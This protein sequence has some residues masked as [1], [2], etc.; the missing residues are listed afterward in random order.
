MKKKKLLAVI[1]IIALTLVFAI[2]LAACTKSGTTTGGDDGTTTG[3]DDGTEDITDP[4]ATPSDVL[5]AA[6]NATLSNLRGF[7]YKQERAYEENGETIGV[8]AETQK[9]LFDAD[10][11]ITHL[12]NRQSEDSDND[13]WFYQTVIVNGML[14]EEYGFEDY[15]QGTKHT[16]TDD[17][18]EDGDY[19]VEALRNISASLNSTNVTKSNGKYTVTLSEEFREELDMPIS[20]LDFTV[21][22]GKVTEITG[23]GEFS[24]DVGEEEEYNISGT[25]TLSVKIYTTANAFSITA[26]TAPEGMTYTEVFVVTF[27][28]P[29][30]SVR[31]GKENTFVITAYD[32]TFPEW[33]S[34]TVQS[35]L[36]VSYVFDDET[37]YS[38]ALFTNAVDID[39]PVTA[40]MT[41]YIKA[42]PRTT[43][44]TALTVLNAIDKSIVKTTY[45]YTL[46]EYSDANQTEVIST[47]IF[48]FGEKYRGQ[49][50][51]LKS[52]FDGERYGEPYKEWYDNSGTSWYGT[53]Y[54]IE[55]GE[56]YF[57]P[58]ASQSYYQSISSIFSSVIISEYFDQFVVTLRTGT[59]D[60]Y[61][62]TLEGTKVAEIVINADGLVKTYKY[63]VYQTLVYAFDYTGSTVI[64]AKPTAEWTTFFKLTVVFNN[65]DEG[66][67][68]WDYVLSLTEEEFYNR[69]SL[70]DYDYTFAYTDRACTIPVVFPLVLTE[71]TTI[72]AKGVNETDP[73]KK[74]IAGLKKNGNQLSWDRVMREANGEEIIDLSYGGQSGTGYAEFAIWGRPWLQISLSGYAWDNIYEDY[75]F[76]YSNYEDEDMTFSVIDTTVIIIW[77]EGEGSSQ[78]SV[79]VRGEIMEIDGTMGILFGVKVNVIGYGEATQYLFL[80]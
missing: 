73:T 51:L 29:A 18:L 35:A 38:T 24:E 30:A 50:T 52:Y 39:A 75:V 8:R 44:A 14:Y 16:V 62:I 61:D 67:S 23:E 80:S 60:T 57:Q 11:A 53:L 63:L 46:T 47:R 59:T 22:N 48:K 10:G 43:D 76:I 20:T 36:K 37:L 79:G 17:D 66:W 70:Y 26:P 65:I 12:F 72:Y 74:F 77:L 27:V 5:K 41:V 7:E 19:L 54:Y 13:A 9:I 55:D 78:H 56:Y 58:E 71:D 42:T 64:P 33:W 40:N 1:L 45:D 49:S 25:L 4:N 69:Y 32:G 31:D 15:W 3:G 34:Y 28:L 2:A 21:V 6:I 68:Q